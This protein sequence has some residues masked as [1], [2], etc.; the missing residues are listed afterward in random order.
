[1]VTENE[2]PLLPV[3]QNIMAASLYVIVHTVLYLVVHAVHQVQQY[4]TPSPPVPPNILNGTIWKNP[5]RKTYRSHFW[6]D[7]FLS[8]TMT[9]LAPRLS[10]GA[11]GVLVRTLTLTGFPATPFVRSP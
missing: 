1:V 5:F 2:R 8:H 4:A 7:H 11:R 6:Q 3:H 9:L 10:S